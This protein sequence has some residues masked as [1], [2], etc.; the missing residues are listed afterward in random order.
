MYWKP[1]RHN[2]IPMK[3]I[4][5]LSSLIHYHINKNIDMIVYLISH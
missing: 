2:F 4:S 3:L 1:Y 5:Y